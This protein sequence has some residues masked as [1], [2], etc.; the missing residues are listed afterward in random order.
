VHAD[1]NPIVRD[2]FG[3]A[4]AGRMC[5]PPTPGHSLLA[6]SFPANRVLAPSYHTEAGQAPGKHPPRW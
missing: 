2:S 1:C 4:K 6:A 3:N 5:D